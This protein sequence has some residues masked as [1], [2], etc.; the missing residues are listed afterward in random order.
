MGA[1]KN[2]KRVALDVVDSALGADPL[3]RHDWYSAE[4][5]HKPERLV[6]ETQEQYRARQQQ[7]RDAAQA[8]RRPPKQAPAESATDFRRFF[9]GQR[10][11]SKPCTG[12][13]AAIRLAKQVLKNRRSASQRLAKE[14]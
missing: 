11:G 14:A 5:L 2:L 3:R 7:S 4:Q 1:L 6:G 13:T 8:S 9:L 10:R 12:K